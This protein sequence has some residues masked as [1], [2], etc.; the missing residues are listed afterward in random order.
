MGPTAD[1]GDQVDSQLLD[2]LVDM[3]SRHRI[4][5]GRSSRGRSSPALEEGIRLLIREGFVR[6]LPKAPRDLEAMLL[7]VI[8]RLQLDAIYEQHPEARPS[9]AAVLAMAR[10]A[11]VALP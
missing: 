11:G 2:D 1:W 6:Q 7:A 5:T 9:D 8:L 4:A 3:L 10:R